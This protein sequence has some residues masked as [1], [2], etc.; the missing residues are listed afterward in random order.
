MKQNASILTLNIPFYHGLMR[1][2]KIANTAHRCIQHRKADVTISVFKFS[3][4]NS[5]N[6]SQ[7][8]QNQLAYISLEMIF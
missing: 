3:L 5:V 6:G 4:L 7:S 2:I 1:I 8:R